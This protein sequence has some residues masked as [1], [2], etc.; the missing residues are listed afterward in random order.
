VTAASKDEPDARRRHG[1]MAWLPR[2]KGK[3]AAFWR[4]ERAVKWPSYI[5]VMAL[6]ASVA[7]SCVVAQ[8]ALPLPRVP[9]LEGVALPPGQSENPIVV[10]SVSEEKIVEAFRRR[11]LFIPEVPVESRELS[12]VVINE[13]LSRMSITAVMR[14]DDYLV[15]Y[16]DVKG[17]ARGSDRGASGASRL[18]GV[19][20][21]D[22]ID[23]FKVENI[24]TDGV[25][26][27]I[28]GFKAKLS[29]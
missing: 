26:L 9:G 24:T 11:K 8:L 28:Q 14:Q 29:F 4:A 19:K 20:V 25:D 22:N 7:L 27:S 17:G 6:V 21:G 18:V 2:H 12:Q 13:M 15:A 1:P 16:I 23:D 5:K 10:S 3:P